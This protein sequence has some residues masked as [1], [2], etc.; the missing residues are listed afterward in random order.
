LALAIAHQ[1]NTSSVDKGVKIEP[2]SY[3]EKPLIVETAIT[4]DNIGA[5]ISLPV[6]SNV[7]VTIIGKSNEQCVV[8]AR[9]ISGK[10]VSGVA[11]NNLVNT[12]SPS[13]GDVVKLNEGRVGHLA[14]VV[15]LQDDNII[16]NEANYVKGYITRRQIAMDDPRILGFIH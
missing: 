9:R 4:Q 3:I 2:D 15:G 13:V 14:V 8:Y 5:K 1:L 7:K 12:E 10:D 6:K 11:K 16:I